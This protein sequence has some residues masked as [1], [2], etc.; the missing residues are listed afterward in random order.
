MTGRVVPLRSVEERLGLYIDLLDLSE[1]L[2][3]HRCSRRSSSNV[4]VM[5][6][7]G[8]QLEGVAVLDHPAPLHHHH[9]V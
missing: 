5:G 1:F 7:L 6:F 9:H 4:V 3:Y 8:E 2:A